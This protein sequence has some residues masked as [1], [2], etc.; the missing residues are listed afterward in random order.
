PPT[1]RYEAGA[2]GYPTRRRG[3][4]YVGDE[5]RAPGTSA[6]ARTWAGAGT[7]L[8]T[9]ATDGRDRTTDGPDEAAGEDPRRRGCAIA[10]GVLAVMI[11]AAAVAGWFG[12]AWGPDQIDPP[13]A[14]GG[15]VPGEVRDGTTTSGIGH[16]MAD[17]G[18]ITNASVWD[19]YIK[20]RDVG[21]FQA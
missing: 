11:L 2:T 17:A 7:D 14:Q 1:S 8:V 21:S 6:R 9:G 10:L 20:L 18:V 3:A 19:W 13:G 16:A 4:T 15:E 12:W 5:G